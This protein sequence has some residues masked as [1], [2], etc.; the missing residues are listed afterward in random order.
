ENGNAEDK[1]GMTHVYRAIKDGTKDFVLGYI[2]QGPDMNCQHT[3]DGVMAFIF[4]LV[5][6]KMLT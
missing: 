4:V 6:Q 1:Y 3:V 2:R 5:T